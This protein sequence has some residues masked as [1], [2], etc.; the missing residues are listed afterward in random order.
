MWHLVLPKHSLLKGLRP[1]NSSTDVPPL[2]VWEGDAE[3]HGSRSHA[4]EGRTRLGLAPP[5]R[6]FL[7]ERAAG[8]P[9]VVPV[10]AAPEKS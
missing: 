2:G 3:G 7:P 10:A 6:R 9:R 1:Q 5:A 4:R 8:A